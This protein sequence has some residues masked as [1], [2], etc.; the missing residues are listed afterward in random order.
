M[1]LLPSRHFITHLELVFRLAQLILLNTT[2]SKFTM[3]TRKGLKVSNDRFF[4]CFVCLFNTYTFIYLYQGDSLFVIII[5][6]NNIR[7]TCLQ[8]NKNY[9]KKGD[10]VRVKT[11]SVIKR[12]PGPDSVIKRLFET[13]Y[14]SLVVFF[15]HQ[16]K[17]LNILQFILLL[18]AVKQ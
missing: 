18:G 5:N 6:I 8:I 11:D 15:R 9:L 1:H 10:S 16:L 13:C 14:F 7:N 17:C 2:C 12:S 4:V 3:T